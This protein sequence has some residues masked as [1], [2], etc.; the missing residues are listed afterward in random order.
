MF[1]TWEI[2]KKKKKELSKLPRSQSLE[3]VKKEIFFF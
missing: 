2:K 1:L 3:M